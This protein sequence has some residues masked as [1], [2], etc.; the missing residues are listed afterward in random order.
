MSD[1]HA[2]L[3]AVA[4]R[5]GAQNVKFESM[6]I[7]EGDFARHPQ[8]TG[9]VAGKRFRIT[10]PGRKKDKPRRFL[11]YAT[12]LRRELVALGAK[13]PERPKAERL[14]RDRMRRLRPVEPS[15]RPLPPRPPTRLDCDP[16][17]PLAQLR[18]K[19]EGMGL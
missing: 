10:L 13:P 9:T 14:G 15:T 6:G 11:N 19:L 17:A 4:V 5:M 2:R 7:G 12:K 18:A 8:I 1:F 3:I 16:W